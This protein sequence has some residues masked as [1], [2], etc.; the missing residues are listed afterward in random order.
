M[1]GVGGLLL[2]A[3]LAAGD[4]RVEILLVIVGGLTGGIGLLT[5]VYARVRENAARSRS[6]PRR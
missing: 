2:L 1:T 3:A 5:L 6:R 4:Q